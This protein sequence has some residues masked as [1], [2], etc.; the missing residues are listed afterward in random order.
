MSEKLTDGEKAAIRRFATAI[1]NW[2][3]EAPLAP[4]NA[5]VLDEVVDSF[6]ALKAELDKPPAGRGRPT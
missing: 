2:W 1:K 3:W 6:E 4:T 5:P